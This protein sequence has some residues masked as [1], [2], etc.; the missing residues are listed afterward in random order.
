MRKWHRWLSFIFGAFLLFIAVTGVLSH[1]AAMYAQGSIFEQEETKV[2]K[3]P[4]TY[5][6]AE[7]ELAAMKAEKA[8]QDAKRANPKRKLVGLMHHLHSGEWF[9]KIGVVVSLLS[10]LAMIFFSFSGLWLY[11]QMFVRRR[12]LGKAELFWK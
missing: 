10:G 5:A 7:E 12:K 9:G 2:E 6:N 4:V 11:Y 1:V 8:E 3:P